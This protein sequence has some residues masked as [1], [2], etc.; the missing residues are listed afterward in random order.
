MQQLCKKRKSR[1]GESRGRA[2]STPTVEPSNTSYPVLI[3]VNDDQR[4]HAAVEI[5]GERFVGLLDSGAQISVVGSKFVEILAS[6]RLIAKPTQFNIIT[7]DGT[8]HKT[9]Q[10]VTLPITYCGTTHEIE[11]PIMESLQHDLILGVDFW[12]KFKI[13]QTIV[14]VGSIEA[15]KQI[16]VSEEMDSG[17][18]DS[19]QLQDVL[20]LMSFGKGG[21]LSKTSL[22]KHTIETGDAK[23]IK[24]SQYIISPY[25][26]KEVHAEIR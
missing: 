15:N 19:K 24:Q 2:E 20:R 13:R 6:G 14:E 12:Q 10:V 17:E 22:L 26:Q 11:A 16:N 3:K 23:P 25:V 7:A 18:A 9:A 1:F 21:I 5:A 8:V 4:F